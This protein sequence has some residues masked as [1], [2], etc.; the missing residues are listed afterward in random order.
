MGMLYSS[1]N[2]ASVSLVTQLVDTLVEMVQ[3]NEANQVDVLDHKVLDC[4]NYL[5]RTSEFPGC[6]LGEVYGLR[7]SLAIFLVNMIQENSASGHTALIAQSIATDQLFHTLQAAFRVLHEPDTALVEEKKLIR[8]VGFL[9]YHLLRRCH[10]LRP[11]H[12][13]PTAYHSSPAIKCISILHKGVTSIKRSSPTLLVLG[14]GGGEI[15]QN[16]PFPQI[17]RVP[18]YAYFLGHG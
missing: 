12:Q 11:S 9:Y 6:S 10:D 17:I 7:R 16:I 18:R 15:P 13:L 8:G 3:G 1:V 14:G 2:S 5:L 4:I